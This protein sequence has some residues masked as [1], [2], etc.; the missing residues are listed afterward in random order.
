MV[1]TCC[2]V[3]CTN[4]HSAGC[5]I[6]FFR[7]PADASQQRAWLA[8]IRRRNIDGSLWTPS[9]HDRVC[10]NHFVR[11]RPVRDPAH[12]DYAPSQHMG[13]EIASPSASSSIARASRRESLATRREETAQ[14]LRATQS[15]LEAEVER[16][17]VASWHDHGYVAVVDDKLAR[18]AKVG[19]Q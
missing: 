6:S 13:W 3:N 1:A 15:N 10:S 19:R 14:R 18:E 5:G 12:P 9:P 4:R 7:F 16:K 2:V 17:R 8:A 11:G